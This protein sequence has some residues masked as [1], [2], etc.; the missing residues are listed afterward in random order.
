MP[1]MGS[2]HHTRRPNTFDCSK[3]R[4]SEKLILEIETIQAANRP[5]AGLQP[6]RVVKKKEC[7]ISRH[8]YVS[9]WLQM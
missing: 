9:R 7:F 5:A 1:F 2:S 6:V 8:V 4:N 3:V